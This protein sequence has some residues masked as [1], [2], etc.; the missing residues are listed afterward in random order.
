MDG[1]PPM[2]WGNVSNGGMY[3][4]WGPRRFSSRFC[5]VLKACHPT[6][7]ERTYR[8]TRPFQE[9]RELVQ[10]IIVTEEVL[11]TSGACLTK[12]SCTCT[13]I[14]YELLHQSRWKGLSASQLTDDVAAMLVV[15]AQMSFLQNRFHLFF[16]DVYHIRDLLFLSFERMIPNTESGMVACSCPRS[17]QSFPEMIFPLE[18]EHR[19]IFR[20]IAVSA[21][22]VK[23][24]VPRR[25]SRNRPS[26]ILVRRWWYRYH[27]MQQGILLASTGLWS[28]SPFIILMKDSMR[29]AQVRI[30]VGI[31][32][33]RILSLIRSNSGWSFWL[34]LFDTF[35]FERRTFGYIIVIYSVACY[36]FVGDSPSYQ[37]FFAIRSTR[38]ERPVSFT[39]QFERI[40]TTI[41]DSIFR[42]SFDGF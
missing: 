38:S 13:N 40:G 12:G 14:F 39:E 17:S 25:Y 27:R 24:D 21:L 37:I 28:T 30:G 42:T 31:D 18:M 4:H 19:A 33:R 35:A 7:V 23:N 6:S 8:G 16:R 29:P 10:D 32:Q 3:C 5:L 22:I 34:H 36:Q 11:R 41:S 15:L 1:L 9:A 26:G 2:I 20:H